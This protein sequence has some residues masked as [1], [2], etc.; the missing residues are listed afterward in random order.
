MCIRSRNSV[1][2]ANYH[3]SNPPAPHPAGSSQEPCTSYVARKNIPRS[4]I[5]PARRSHRACFRNGLTG[6]T[7]VSH[8]VACAHPAPAARLRFGWPSVKPPINLLPV[9]VCTSVRTWYKQTTTTGSSY[10]SRT[11]GH[12][13]GTLVCI[14]GGP[15]NGVN[16]VYKSALRIAGVSSY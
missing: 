15:G 10:N 11:A 5:S 16:D 1:A 13:R 6:V 3:Q 12:K 14:N 2:Q 4:K 9:K 8:A 7:L